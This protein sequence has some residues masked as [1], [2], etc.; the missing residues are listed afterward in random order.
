[1]AVDEEIERGSGPPRVCMPSQRKVRDDAAWCSMFEFEDVISQVDHVDR[2][3]LE[4]AKGFSWRQHAVNSL[5]WRQWSRQFAR[6]N[7]GLKPTHITR[8]YDIFAFLVINPWEL[9]YLNA[10][11]GWK[12]RCRTKIC[13]IFEVWARIIHRYEHLLRLLESFDHVFI[14]FDSSVQPAR[15]IIGAPCHQLSPAPDVLRFTPFPNPPTRSI[16]VYSIGRRIEMMHKGLVKMAREGEI[17]YIY[18]TIPG[19]FVKP[20]DYREHRELYANIAKRSRFFVTYPAKVDIKEETCGVSE[21]GMRFY[22]GIASGAVLVGQ[23]PT[24]QVFKDEF[25]WPDSVLEIG[26]GAQNLV[27]VMQRFKREP[28]QYEQLSRKNASEALSHHDV[29]HRWAQILKTIG[30]APLPALSARQKRLK[31]L[32]AMAT[33]SVLA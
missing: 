16:D 5:V 11:H 3:D 32:A 15:D 33:D 28:E 14:E 6:L 20:K 23:P 13:F 2:I 27:E 4:P 18:D 26:D 29:S 30:S 7:P 21:P 8:D 31:Q 19:T 12:E 22:E 1:M 24:C 17:F 9:L 25:Y 10:I